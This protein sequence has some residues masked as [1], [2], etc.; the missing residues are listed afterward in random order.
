MNL[1]I[2]T[3]VLL[4]TIQPGIE[5]RLSFAHIH[6]GT[7]QTGAHRQSHPFQK[8]IAFSITW[9][10]DQHNRTDLAQALLY[11]GHERQSPHENK[12]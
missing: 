8:I 10:I 3:S 12:P 2:E 5:F 7:L 6:C 9:N 1:A 11:S 4:P